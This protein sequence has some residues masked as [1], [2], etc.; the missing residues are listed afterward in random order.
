MG[1]GSGS[2]AVDCVETLCDV[3]GVPKLVEIDVGDVVVRHR[4]R[5]AVLVLLPLKTMNLVKR[6]SD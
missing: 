1:G 3:I 4:K 6:K 5:R 2:G